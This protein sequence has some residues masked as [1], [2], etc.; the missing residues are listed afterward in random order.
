MSTHALKNTFL[1]LRYRIIVIRYFGKL[2]RS[3]KRRSLRIG[4]TGR[5]RTV[6]TK[7][8]SQL[9]AVRGRK[10]DQ[11]TL[12]QIRAR[13]EPRIRAVEPK[14]RGHPFVNL[15]SEADIDKDDPVFRQALS[16]EVLEIADDYFGSRFQIETI[17][18]LY[19]YPTQ[20]PLRE[21][22]KWHRDFGDSKALHFI[23]YV[24]DLEDEAGGPFVYLDKETSKRVRSSPI[25]RRISDE[26]ILE[27]T[28]NAPWHKFFGGAG[29]TL[30]VDPTACYHFGSRC[31]TPR[32]ALFLT[33]NTLTPFAPLSSPINCNRSLAAS[34]A[35]EVRPDLSPGYVN[36][37]FGI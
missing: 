6:E 16:P 22:Q 24:N 35:R 2:W 29:S 37:L 34:V 9:G 31:S 13:Y 17:Q 23:S 15:W 12:E 32:M 21:S 26:K 20:G 27:E 30:I 7:A 1:F 5:L 33:F 28:D 25:I 10:I 18:V 3:L 36:Q 19:S 11:Q 4:N 8:V 14:D